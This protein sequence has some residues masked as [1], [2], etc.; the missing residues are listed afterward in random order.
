MVPGIVMYGLAAVIFTWLGIASCLR[1]RWARALILAGSW[2]WLATGLVGMVGWLLLPSDF[3]Q[4]VIE[5]NPNATPVPPGVL[6]AMQI[7]VT[8]TLV[9]VYL[10]IPGVLVLGYGRSSVKAT[11]E[12]YCPRPSWTDRCPVPVLAVCLMSVMGAAGMLT[13]PAMDVFP[14]FGSLQS[15]AVYQILGVALAVVWLGLAVWQYRL[16]PVAWALTIL[17]TVLFGVS[18]VLT[19]MEVPLL[20]MYRRMGYTDDML[21]PIQASGLADAFNMPAW[22]SLIVILYLGYLAVI[23]GYFF[24]SRDRAELP[25]A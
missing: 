20:E 8:A 2:V 18:T 12:H 6:A 22:I 5:A 1:R 15:G 17:L 11:C 7:G 16:S 24:G 3:L 9:L 25:A 13:M 21:R 10:V 19:F 23:R 4:R 14:W